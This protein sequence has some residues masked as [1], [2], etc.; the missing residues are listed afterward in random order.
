MTSVMEKYA[1]RL[2]PG[3]AEY[4][5]RAEELFS[6]TA[7]DMT[8]EDQRRA[9]TSLCRAFA[10]PHPEGLSVRDE[11][12]PG[13][14]G[15]TEIRVYRPAGE[16]A[17]PGL[18]YFHGG[19]WVVGN[20][21]SH[22]DHCAWMAGEAGVVVVAVDYPLSPENRHPVAF[23]ASDAAVRHIAAHAADY[24]IDP[25]RLGV[26]GDSAGAALAA[27]VALKARDEGG[28]ALALQLLIYPTLGCDHSLPSFAENADA[29]ALTTV[30]MAKYLRL[31]TGQ[32]PAQITD[33]HAAPLL[34][35][36]L[37]GMPPAMIAACGLDPLRDEA[38]AWH[39]RLEGAGVPSRHYL[40]DG[41]V[42][43]CMR[44]R[45]MSAPA[46]RFFEAICEGLSGL[47]D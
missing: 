2:A 28:P 7:V 25:D 24:G 22:D 27:A 4:L 41:L 36:D 29:P 45:R 5:A 6:H 13:P 1:G 32:D 23:Q 34:A 38:A 39:E 11:T 10:G 47:R 9:F 16:G 17:L 21:D 20:L 46:M 26:G 15:D 37:S 31:Y 33:V 8:V 18:I 42:H 40:G 19:G 43:G 44:A 30:D 35:T 12:V 14:D 3:M